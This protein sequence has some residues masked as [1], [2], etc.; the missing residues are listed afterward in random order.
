M[1]RLHL[2]AIFTSPQQR[3]LPIVQELLQPPDALLLQEGPDGPDVFPFSIPLPL[4][5]LSG[6]N[7]CCPGEG[8]LVEAEV[9]LPVVGMLVKPSF[10]SILGY[11]TGNRALPDIQA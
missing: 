3:L 9:V 5:H 4:G 2:S 10:A 7:A 1:E 11:F 8:L 6:H